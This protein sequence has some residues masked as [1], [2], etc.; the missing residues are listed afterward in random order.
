MSQYN[1]LLVYKATYVLLLAIFQFTKQF[2]KEYK[3]T[4]GESLRSNLIK[5][6]EK[7]NET[8]TN[9]IANAGLRV[10]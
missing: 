8:L 1:E 3:Y 7:T 4:V 10:R 9:A 5:L 6:E 2:R